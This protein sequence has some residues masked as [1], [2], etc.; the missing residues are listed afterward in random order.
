MGPS[1]ESLPEC[2]YIFVGAENTN[3]KNVASHLDVRLKERLK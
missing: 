1:R 2:N 3:D